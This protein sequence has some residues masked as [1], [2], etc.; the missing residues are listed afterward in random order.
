MAI[1]SQNIISFKKILLD[2]TKVLEIILLQNMKSVNTILLQNT[3]SSL[4]QHCHRTYGI[5]YDTF[6]T[7]CVVFVKTILLQNI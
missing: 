5:C 2:S 3:Q 1:S 6:A 7:E 4:R